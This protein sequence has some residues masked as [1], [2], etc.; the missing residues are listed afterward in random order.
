MAVLPIRKYPDEVLK[1]KAAPVADINGSLQRVIRDMVETMYAAPGIG[2]AAPQVGESRRLIVLDLSTKEEKQPLIVLINP[3][4]IDTDGMIESD[5]G[6]LSVPGYSSVIKR[7]AAVLVRGLDKEGKPV[8]IEGT[9]LL[10]RALQHEIDHLD[11]ILY[12]DRMSAIK[13]EFFKKRYQ[14]TLS[15]LRR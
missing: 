7:A 8:E 4:I 15:E 14:K 3:E 10:A 13:R 6:C 11:G 5:E 2:L 12:I 9:G 1:K